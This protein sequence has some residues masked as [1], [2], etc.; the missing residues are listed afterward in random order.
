[1]E[2]DGRPSH[3][4]DVTEIDHHHDF[5]ELVLVLEGAG[6]HRLEGNEFPVSAGDVFVIQGR[7]VHSFRERR[8]LV[9]LNVMYAPERL[10]LPEG[11]LRPLPGYSALFLLEPNFRGS[12]AFSS[13]LRLDR[14]RLGVA[15]E[16]GLRIA[17]EA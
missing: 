3:P 1:T 14:A 7:Q 6:T 2:P 4:H 13:R 17:D 15:E 9:L 5:V 12:H 10:S 11:L 16:L 8:G